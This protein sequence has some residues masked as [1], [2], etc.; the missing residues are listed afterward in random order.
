MRR[1][2]TGP[3]RAAIPNGTPPST[4]TSACPPKA[5]TQSLAAGWSRSRRNLSL[6]D[7]HGRGYINPMKSPFPGM[8]PFLE[9]YWG[10]VHHSL[11]QYARDTMQP[12][13][14]AD[15]RARVEER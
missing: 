9:Q 13:L 6:A 1:P 7:N 10:D 11:I 2:R 3:A 5:P 14:P 12:Q 4:G 8:D 15:L